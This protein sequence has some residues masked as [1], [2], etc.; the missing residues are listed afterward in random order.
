VD[1]G[2]A[3][4]EATGER[5]VE[6]DL[7]RLRGELLAE[8]KTADHEAAMVAFDAAVTVA[9]DQ[10]A[11]AAELRA[12]TSRQTFLDRLGVRSNVTGLRRLLASF[13]QVGEVTEPYVAAAR[14]AA[15]KREMAP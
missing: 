3:H 5:F 6:A 11:K 8:Q 4:V 15:A 14:I 13:E 2:L 10:Q 1:E 12:L 7:L 9:R